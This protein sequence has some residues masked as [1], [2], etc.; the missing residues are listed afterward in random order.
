MAVIVQSFF[1]AVALIATV[2]LPLTTWATLTIA[3][4]TV[5]LVSIF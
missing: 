1:N 2:C 4:V 5:Y 3:N